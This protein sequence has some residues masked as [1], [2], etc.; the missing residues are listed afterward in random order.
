MSLENSKWY[1]P[2]TGGLLYDTSKRSD[3]GP[4]DWQANIVTAH[5]ADS[6]REFAL[7]FGDFQLAYTR[8]SP[9]PDERTGDPPAVPSNPVF[10][11]CPPPSGTSQPP[12]AVA[13]L[14]QQLNQG[15]KVSRAVAAS[16]SSL[17]V[18]L[19]ANATVTGLNGKWQITNPLNTGAN[20]QTV[21]TDPKVVCDTY[22]VTGS[23]TSPLGLQVA[24]PNMPAGWSSPINALNPPLDTANQLNGPPYPTLISVV[25][26]PG[27]FALNYRNEPIPF[28]TWNPTTQS[29]PAGKQGDLSFAYASIPRADEDMNRQPVP[30]SPI[31]PAQTN[32]NRFKFSANLLP[33]VNG[34]APCLG[35]D[36][37]KVQPCDPY[38]PT[39]RAYANDKVQVRTLVGE[40]ARSALLLDSGCEMAVRTFGS[41]L[42]LSQ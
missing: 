16:F 12:C 13:G 11:I 25:P 17:G 8:Q 22:T 10:N 26:A 37:S 5:E 6:Y 36:V 41:Q 1:D 24:T 29:I 38:T 39:L 19:T 18:T 34:P 4:T 21:C 35:G 23:A 40:P 28:R 27:T 9:A 7:E 2:T 20:G 3:G 33:S 32:K 15:G 30:G 31:D 14:I 42:G